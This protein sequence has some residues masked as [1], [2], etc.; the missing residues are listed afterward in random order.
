[1][2]LLTNNI[3]QIAL[4]LSFFNTINAM[5]RSS[6]DSFFDDVQK[7]VKRDIVLYFIDDSENVE[8]AIKHLYMFQSINKSSY[9]VINDPQMCQSYVRSLHKKFNIRKL[10]VRYMMHTKAAKR[11][12]LERMK[13]ISQYA[14][15]YHNTILRERNKKVESARFVLEQTCEILHESRKKDKT[16]WDNTQAITNNYNALTSC[17]K[18]KVKVDAYKYPFYGEWSSQDLLYLSENMLGKTEG[19]AIQMFNNPAMKEKLKHRFIDGITLFKMIES[20]IS[21]DFELD[22]IRPY[23]GKSRICKKIEQRIKVIQ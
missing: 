20:Q 4:F 11:L 3:R 8:T 21:N 17:K 7:E 18:I 13:V 22:C 10:F 2:K 16:F 19:D 23:S 14:F 6:E 1:M 5:E 15:L 9:Q 12:L